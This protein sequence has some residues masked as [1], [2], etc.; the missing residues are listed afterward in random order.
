MTESQEVNSTAHGGG[1]TEVS[2]GWVSGYWDDWK[3]KLESKAGVNEA[4][5]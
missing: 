3:V 2:C 4:G 5:L 1:P